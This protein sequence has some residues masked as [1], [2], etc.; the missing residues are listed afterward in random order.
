MA[1]TLGVLLNDRFN[2][3]GWL[4]VADCFDGG[5]S[6]VAHRVSALAVSEGA[7]SVRG[8][9]PE[10]FRNTEIPRPA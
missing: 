8:P 5:R 2:A 9:L 4:S 7:A 6:G 1:G 10:A 3:L